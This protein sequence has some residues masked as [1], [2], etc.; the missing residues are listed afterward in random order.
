MNDVE[1]SIGNPFAY[2]LEDK[3]PIMSNMYWRDVPWTYEWRNLRDDFSAVDT[4]DWGLS[5]TS[6]LLSCCKLQ[7]NF[8]PKF[9]QIHSQMAVLIEGTTVE[10]SY[11]DKKVHYQHALQWFNIKRKDKI[12]TCD[13]NI[14]SFQNPADSLDPLY[15]YYWRTVG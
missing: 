7:H 3:V 13:K 1:D 2:A 12:G 4:V 9:G 14:T 11:T 10:L 6:M 15:N 5:R 8:C